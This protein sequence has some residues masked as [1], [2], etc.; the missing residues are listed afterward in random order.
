MINDD[1]LNLFLIIDDRILR[2]KRTRAEIGCQ[3][4]YQGYDLQFHLHAEMLL[5]NATFS[6]K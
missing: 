3:C 4:R 6:S 2:Q 5:H 1:G